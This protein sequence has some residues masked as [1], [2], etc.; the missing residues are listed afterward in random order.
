MVIVTYFFIG[1]PLLPHWLL[2]PI[3]SKGSFYMHFPTDRTAH[4]K[5]FDG[6]FVDNWLEW[7][8]V[9]TANASAIQDR[10]VDPNLYK[11][12]ALPP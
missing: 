8:I 12:G 1:N 7:K 5:A 10:S 6:P 4:T 9:Q 3:S 11:M 2:F